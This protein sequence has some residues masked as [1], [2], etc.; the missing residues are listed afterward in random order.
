[1]GLAFVPL[2]VGDAFSAL[3]YSSCV[4]VEAEGRWLL[5]DCPHPIRKILHESSARAGVPLDVGSF[6]AVVVTHVHADHASGLEGLGFYSHF[7]LRKRARLL[8][9]PRVADDLRVGR[10]SGGMCENGDP[11]TGSSRCKG[12]ADYFDLE[13]LDEARA[14]RLG[15][16]EIECRRT[17]HV[18]P[19]TALR[20]RAGGRCLGL[21]SDT[22]FDPR[23]VAWLA[24]A[25]LFLHETG[26][27]IH[28]SYEALAAL[29]A[30]V[31]AMARL[32]HY[33]DAFDLA[34]SAIE[35]LV[36]GRRYEL[37]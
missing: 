36:E 22:C 10:L 21:S 31:R 16:F 11:A 32:I 20:I 37:P 33:P 5:V 17:K 19:T 15:P 8:A 9:L 18:V 30:E 34:A 26:P 13:P 25:D 7:V 23:L 1:M 14:I 28:T 12:F 35:P 29:P 27:G 3:R 6:E 24:E 4:A 2:G